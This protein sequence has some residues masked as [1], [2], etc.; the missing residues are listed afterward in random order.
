MSDTKNDDVNPKAKD[1]SLHDSTEES[2]EDMCRRIRNSLL[3]DPM[4]EYIMLL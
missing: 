1:G 2:V 4:G 3:V